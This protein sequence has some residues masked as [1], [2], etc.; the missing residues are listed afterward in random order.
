[1]LEVPRGRKDVSS[2]VFMSGGV[3]AQEIIYCHDIDENLLLAILEDV[4]DLLVL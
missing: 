1:M 2:D 4:T 3:L